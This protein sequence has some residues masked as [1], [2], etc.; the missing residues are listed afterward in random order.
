MINVSELTLI[1]IFVTYSVNHP[2][3]VVSYFGAFSLSPSIR[4]AYCA[5]RKSI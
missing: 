5:I 1:Y 4:S 2:I 3:I